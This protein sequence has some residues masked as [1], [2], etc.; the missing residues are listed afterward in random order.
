MNHEEIKDTCTLSFVLI[1]SRKGD[2]TFVRT[3]GKYF[4]KGC[5]G[6]VEQLSHKEKALKLFFSRQTYSKVMCVCVCEC[7]CV[8]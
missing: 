5:N 7:M 6:G 1:S 3:G 8:I 4:A 2:R